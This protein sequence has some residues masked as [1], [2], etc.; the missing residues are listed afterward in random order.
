[1]ISLAFW[2]Y[3]ISLLIMFSLSEW[4]SIIFFLITSDAFSSSL[5]NIQLMNKKFLLHIKN[6]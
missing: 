2:P 3:L 6:I 4:I 5:Q 1:M